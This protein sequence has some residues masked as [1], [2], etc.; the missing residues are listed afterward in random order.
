MNIL[1]TSDIHAGRRH[2]FSMLSIA[3]K[4][5]VDG[6]IIGGDIV[7]HHLP[8]SK[9]GNPITAQG[10]Y[11]TDV[12]IPAI[13]RFKAARPVRIFLDMSNDD[14]AFNRPLLE[15]HHGDLFH[16][17]HMEKHPLTASVDLIGYMNVPPTPFQRKDWEK[18]DAPAWPHAPGGYVS[19]RG[20]SSAGGILNKKIL[21]P[22]SD[23]TIERD[24]LKLSEQIDKSFIF[25]S[26]TP[27]FNT[28]LD[29]IADG[30][31]VG[32]MSV[33]KFIEHWAAE[34]KIKASLHGH[35]H[36]S[37]R[38]SGVVQAE[39]AGVLCL[40]PGQGNGDNS[41]FQYGILNLGTQ[42]ENADRVVLTGP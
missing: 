13:E 29:V 32:S 4:A 19:L 11:L 1:Y 8:G 7:P 3:E 34:K 25:V 37:P 20:Y 33:R 6:I 30:T 36:E 15:K 12:F 24:L 2:L 35:I 31:H 17:L 40:N 21:S 10:R 42:G 26:H 9:T 5:A 39:I 23:D 41:A 22:D 28:P 27:P 38:R 18:P 14:F 16:L